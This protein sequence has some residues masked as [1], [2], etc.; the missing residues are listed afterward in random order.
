MA[1]EVV[2]NRIN[3]RKENKFIKKINDNKY[4]LMLFLP[5]M[6]VFFLFKYVPLFGLTMA[7]Q[8]YNFVDGIFGSEWVG[9]YQFKRLFS[10]SGFLLAFK[11]T[12]KI[13]LLNLLFG[14]PAPVILAILLNEVKNTKFKRTVQTISYLPH[15]FSWVV[16]SGLLAVFLAPTDG[17]VNKVINFLGGK[18]IY[19]LADKN[20]F[21]PTLVVS[22]I[23]KEI[24][25]GSIV[26]LAA[27]TSISTDLY[28][29]ASIDGASKFQRVI[30]ITL[31][32]LMSTIAVMFI[33][34]LGHILDAGFDQIFNM[35][36]P[37]V[38]DVADIIDTYT[39]R[40]GIGS[41]EYSFST[42]A[43]LFKS[44]IAAIMIVGG[45]F[46][47]KRMGDNEAGIF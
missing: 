7:F 6:L 13:S 34:R 14:F 11:N 18:P 22:S 17:V 43:S 35:Y 2:V 21:V 27:L 32:E 36:N 5:G 38:Y 3:V 47:V 44:I 31:P 30:Y 1:N 8:D 42:A 9:L 4:L 45:N 46:M 15:F 37:A 16:I 19:F 26:Y 33:L 25:W 40:M 41:F 39:Y 29:A 23:W 28:E 24:G 20:W 12:L 10:T